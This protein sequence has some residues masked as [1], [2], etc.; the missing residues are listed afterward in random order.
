M[1][2]A[3]S[4]LLAVFFLGWSSHSHA[5]L[6]SSEKAAIGFTALEIKLGLAMP[7][8]DSVSVTMV[9]APESGNYRVN[10]SHP[11]FAGKTFV[12]PSGG[13]TSASTHATIVGFYFFG[14]DSLAPGI[15]LT[16]NGEDIANYEAN[17][18]LG[19]GYLR[20]NISSQL[21]AVE[22]RDVVNHS[23]IGTTGNTTLDTEII[24]RFDYAIQRD[25]FVATVGLNNGNSTSVPNLMAA[26]YNSIVVGLSNGNHSRNGTLADGV[27]RTKPDIVVPTSATSWATPTVGGAA[28]LLIDAARSGNLTDATRAQ[29]VKSLLMAGAS[30]SGSHVPFAWSNN[31][32]HPLDPIYGAGQLN[33]ENSYDILASGKFL[34]SNS[35]D[36]QHTGWDFGLTALTPRRY[37]FNLPFDAEFT[38]SLTWLRIITPEDTNP[39]PGIYNWVFN[40]SLANLDLRLYQ[41]TGYTVGSLVKSSLSTVDNSELIY[42]NNLLAGRYVLEVT[43]D[44]AG[45][46]Y[47]LAWQSIP[48]PST[49]FLFLAGLA[50]L[51]NLKHRKSSPKVP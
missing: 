9:E 31:S 26:T 18:W 37:F 42:Q 24:R 27:G 19:S 44:T 4:T 39:L 25:D 47:G 46:N 51:Y 1:R 34:A 8:G 10:T 43:S 5:Q 49:W 23:W 32:T 48:E 2:T 30:K 38:A 45:I 21:P 20:F 16:A 36:A 17:N 28:A 22:N 6:S 33:I 35:T 40:S 15:G 29:V 3:L 7:K 12:F 50:I 13:N 14:V 11:S 41:A